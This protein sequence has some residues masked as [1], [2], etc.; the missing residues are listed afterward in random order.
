M[1]APDQLLRVEFDKAAMGA[2]D[3]P[4]HFIAHELAS[5]IERGVPVDVDLVLSAARKVVVTITV[6]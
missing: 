4:L 1:S 2:T 6:E 3:N 5:I